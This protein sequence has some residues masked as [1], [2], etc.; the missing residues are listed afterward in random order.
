VRLQ[1]EFAVRRD[2]DTERV[3]ITHSIPADM[4]SAVSALVT[5]VPSVLRHE[6]QRDG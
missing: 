3:A 6:E 4:A 1:S 5:T 2:R